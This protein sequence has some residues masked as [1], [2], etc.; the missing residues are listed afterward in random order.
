MANRKTMKKLLF[1]IIF[2]ALTHAVFAQQISRNG[3]G[4]RA[5]AMGGTITTLSDSW[6]AANNAAGLAEIRQA[7]A[8]LA[9]ENRFGM[10]EFSTLS[11]GSVIP[12]SDGALGINV[13]QFGGSLYSEGTVSASYAHQIGGVNLGI[14]ANLLQY[15]FETLGS[16]QAV[17]LDFG[18]QNQLSEHLFLGA[19][20]TN[21]F[22]TKLYDYED[23]RT[24]TIIRLGLA[25]RPDEKL[26]I[27]IEADKD[28][29]QDPKLRAGLEYRAAEVLYFRTGIVTGEGFNGSFGLGI[30]HLSGQLDY[31]LTTHSIL[32]LVHQVSLTY[33]FGQEKEF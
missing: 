28:I 5:A 20:V 8:H 10:Q 18:V 27:N 13:S 29:D 9:Y 33:R 3:A 17:T 12:I 23:E 2:L 24:P 22:R 15:R 1:I 14:R 30:E 21:V 25:Y 19:V 4:A 31:A 11:A 32:G 6:S 26:T 16:K 7:S